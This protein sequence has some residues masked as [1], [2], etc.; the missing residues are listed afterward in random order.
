M[1]AMFPRTRVVYLMDGAKSHKRCKN[2]PPSYPSST[3]D[4]FHAYLHHRGMVAEEFGHMKPHNNTTATPD[5]ASEDAPA[6]GWKLQLFLLSESVRPDEVQWEP[7]KIARAAG[8]HVLYTPPC[9]RLSLAPA[10][11]TAWHD[12][13]APLTARLA[14]ARRPPGRAA[15]RALLAQRQ[16]SNRVAAGIA[17][18]R[19]S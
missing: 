1:S 9:A 2:K 8:H 16:E 4:E 15:H 11:A 12:G 7:V 6:G 5:I 3:V 19:A 18:A 13:W 14:R 17:D 10:H